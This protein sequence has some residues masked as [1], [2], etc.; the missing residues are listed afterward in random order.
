MAYYPN[1]PSSTRLGSFCLPSDPTLKNQLLYDAGIERRFN[2]LHALNYLFMGV[3]I[4][5]VLS[6]IWLVLVQCL[7]KIIYW[8]AMVLALFLLVVAMF[9]FFIGSGNTLVNGQGWA[10][11][12][13]IVCLVLA[14]VIVLYSWTHRKQIYIT[15][16]FL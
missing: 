14:V 13:G 9:V 7:P 15:G 4:A 3:W 11:L 2:S 12:L 5:F 10:I 1:Y 8:I 16:C 6:L